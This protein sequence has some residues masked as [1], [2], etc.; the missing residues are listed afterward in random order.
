V[1]WDSLGCDSNLAYCQAVAMGVEKNYVGNNEVNLYPNP[2]TGLFRISIPGESSGSELLLSVYDISGR[3]IRKIQ[4]NPE[5]ENHETDLRDL[6]NG[7]YMIR[8]I[9]DKEVIYTG[10]VLKQ[11]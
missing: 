9:K 1:K 5:Q 3:E 4:L 11:D 8:V 7:L 10:K 2:N 6:N